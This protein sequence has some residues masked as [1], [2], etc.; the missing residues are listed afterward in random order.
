M[1]YVNING[2][3]KQVNQDS[4]SSIGAI[5]TLIV[6]FKSKTINQ[7]SNGTSGRYYFQIN[8]SYNNKTFEAYPCQGDNAFKTK[9]SGTISNG[10]GILGSWTKGPG[11]STG[12]ISD[13]STL[14][15]FI[16]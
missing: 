9:Y 14:I 11:G 6:D 10:E 3:N 1:I 12:I 4:T 2:V 5:D 16:K 15:V 7:S 8:T 13:I